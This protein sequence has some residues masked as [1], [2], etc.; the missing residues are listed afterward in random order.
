[1]A[2]LKSRDGRVRINVVQGPNE[3]AKD[4]KHRQAF[5]RGQVN[6]HNERTRLGRKSEYRKIFGK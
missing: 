6:A 5:A 1:M 2:F 4:F 3:E